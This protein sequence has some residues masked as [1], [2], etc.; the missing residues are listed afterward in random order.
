[1]AVQTTTQTLPARKATSEKRVLIVSGGSVTLE[2]QM[3]DGTWVAEG[4]YADGVYEIN[5]DR[6]QIRVVPA[7]GAS[8]EVLF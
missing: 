2:A 4:T 1:M 6:V 5:N 8:F 7:G 3:S